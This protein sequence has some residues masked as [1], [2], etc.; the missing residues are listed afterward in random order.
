VEPPVRIVE[1]QAAVGRALVE[2]AQGPAAVP[3]DPDRVEAG[4][5]H[6]RLRER[7]LVG[8]RQLLEAP[9]DRADRRLAPP[10]LFPC[11]VRGDRGRVE[12]PAHQHG[13]RPRS[14]ELGADRGAEQCAELLDRFGLAPRA[15]QAEIGPPEDMAP[16]GSGGEHYPAAGGHLPDGAEE[17]GLGHRLT[18]GEEGRERRLVEVPRHARPPRTN[19]EDRRLAG[20]QEPRRAGV[21][22]QHA[23]AG[24]IAR[25]MRLAAAQIEEEKSPWP[26]EAL[27]GVPSAGQ[28][29][30]GQRGIAGPRGLLP[31]KAELAHQILAVVEAAIEQKRMATC[32]I[33]EG[34]ALPALLGGRPER[35]AAERSPSPGAH[36]VAVARRLGGGP[37][38]RGEILDG[39]SIEADLSKKGGHA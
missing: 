4:R 35:P 15:Q 19:E 5:R 12:A 6:H 3:I 39:G 21:P 25:Q 8:R 29:A 10:H 36:R 9:G 16:L 2:T 1:R 31:G 28:V 20:G 24:R 11:R 30:Q 7:A 33:G 13:G 37:E 22:A 17:G 34:L 26:D 18:G 27:Q 23:L 38:E 14:A 32:R